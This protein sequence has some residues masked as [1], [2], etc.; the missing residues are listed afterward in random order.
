MPGRPCLCRRSIRQP[1]TRHTQKTTMQASRLPPSRRTSR[2]QTPATTRTPPSSSRH[3]RRHR[4]TGR[5]VRFRH[6]RRN[7]PRLSERPNRFPHNINRTRMAHITAD[8]TVMVQATPADSPPT[9]GSRTAI[10]QPTVVCRTRR[11]L[12]PRKRRCSRPKA[13][14]ARKDHSMRAL[15]P[16]A[17]MDAQRPAKLRITWLWPLSQPSLRRP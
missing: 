2:R 5:T 9:P 4:N 17:L 15:R 3:T 11:S 13:Q 14:T 1:A 10:R 8:T 12:A 6:S 7:P 16:K